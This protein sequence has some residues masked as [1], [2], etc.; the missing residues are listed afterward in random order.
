MIIFVVSGNFGLKDQQVALQWIKRN[1]KHFGGDSNQITLFGESAG[2]ASIGYHLMNPESADLFHRAILQSGSPD[3]HWSF[4]SSE[5]AKNRFETF[6]SSVGCMN[7]VNVLTCLQSKPMQTLFD[8]EWVTGNYLEFP[9]LPT[10][11]SDFITDN[12]NKLLK[13]G[14]FQTD[15][16]VL[17]GTNKDEG[18]FWILYSVPGL[19]RNDPSP[20]THAM[21]LEGIDIVDWD[22]SSDDRASIA[23]M[24]EPLDTLDGEANTAALDDVSGDRSFTCPTLDLASTLSEVTKTYV[25]YLT[26]RASN[27]VWPK[28]MGVIHGADIQVI[29]TSVFASHKIRIREHCKT[30]DYL[31]VM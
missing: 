20:L 19:S 26:H 4:M 12:P 18:T 24:Y 29:C 14:K 5:V 30:L 9:W 17:L 23:K 13:E 8:N 6:I 15:K 16:E 7:D 11:D 3:S 2:A 21:Y 1:I 22:L 27:E 31:I 28:W 25:Y 10:V